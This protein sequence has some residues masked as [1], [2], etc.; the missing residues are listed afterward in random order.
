[1][2]QHG[3]CSVTFSLLFMV[4][5]YPCN[6]TFIKSN[7]AVYGDHLGVPDGVLKESVRVQ[8]LLSQ[9]L[10]ALSVSFKI[11]VGVLGCVSHFGKLTEPEWARAVEI[12]YLQEFELS[13]VRLC[14]E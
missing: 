13:Y 9:T 5:S 7:G 6:E 10:T 1:M 3:R 8:Q 12:S 11:K 4:S 14:F 2:A